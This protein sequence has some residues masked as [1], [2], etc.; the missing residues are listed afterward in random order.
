M[1]AYFGWLTLREWQIA[2]AGGHRAEDETTAARDVMLAFVT[3][4]VHALYI[5]IIAVSLVPILVLPTCMR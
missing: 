3:L 4:L 1:I 2:R 5:L